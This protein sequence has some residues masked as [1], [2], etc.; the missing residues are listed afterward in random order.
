M[1]ENRKKWKKRRF[2]NLE[3]LCEDGED[4]LKEI[5]WPDI[6]KEYDINGNSLRY[7]LVKDIGRTAKD[8]ARVYING[9]DEIVGNNELDWQQDANKIKEMVQ[10][11]EWNF[12]GCY[13]KEKLASAISMHI[14]RGRRAMQWVYGCV[15]PEYRGLGI[16]QYMGEYIDMIT[17]MS[18]AQ[19]GFLW[20]VTIHDYTQMSVEKAGYMPMGFFPGWSFYGGSDSYYY[21][22]N[23]ILYG[24]VY[25]KSCLQNKE[26]M[27]LTEKAKEMVDT[28]SKSMQ[29]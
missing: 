21:R 9:A 17:E 20:S 24:K 27:Q 4:E 18:G 12:Y 26:S 10:S 29:I 14:L 19:I 16:W 28:V 1:F 7:Q 8:V 23:M 2:G 3:R 22:P 15:D 5:S 25:D 13:F 6:I 11:G